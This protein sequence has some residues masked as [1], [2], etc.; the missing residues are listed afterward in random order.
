MNKFREFM[1]LYKKSIIYIFII[2]LITIMGFLGMY[3][4][5]ILKDGENVVE[6]KIDNIENDAEL[7]LEKKDE[8]E[9]KDKD[10]DLKTSNLVKVDIKGRIKNPGVY[11]VNSD[12]RVLDVI[13]KAGGVTS[14]ADTSVTNL[15]KRITDE[16]VIIIY[17][18]SE[19]KNFVKVKE[20]EKEKQIACKNDVN[21]SCVDNDTKPNVS[22]K[23]SINTATIDELTSL[24][25]IGKE[26]AEAI[27]NYRQTNGKFKNI[28]ELLNIKGI[29]ESIFEKIKD[30][31]T[32]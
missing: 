18:K 14:D 1:F 24:N 32:I 5:G 21:D 17:S 30:N 19:V 3:Y 31:I 15:S 27:I 28:N 13:N 10:K 23:I 6:E 11:N 22:K 25:G 29:G 8:V 20:E 16:M 4:L 26:K 9:A 12:D 2:I 7:K